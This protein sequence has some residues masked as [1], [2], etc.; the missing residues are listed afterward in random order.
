MAASY[1]RIIELAACPRR[2]FASAIALLTSSVVACGLTG[3]GCRAW[4]I[5]DLQFEIPEG[6]GAR[7]AAWVGGGAL[8]VGERG[9]RVGIGCGMPCCGGGACNPTLCIAGGAGA[10]WAWV[11]VA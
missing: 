8:G 10:G 11:I 7:G 3:A 5:S 1:A 4:A 6:A 9:A 2:C